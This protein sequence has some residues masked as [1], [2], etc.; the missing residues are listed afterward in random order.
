MIN[1]RSIPRILTAAIVAQLLTMGATAQ[2][3]EAPIMPTTLSETYDTWTVQCGNTGT[4]DQTKRQCQMSQEL[5]QQD[6][7]QR[8]LLFAV[9]EG[10]GNAK[11]TLILPFGLLLSPGVHIEIA[12]KEL[13]SG[14]FQTCLPQGCL[15]EIELS[16]MALDQ[17]Q[18][19]EKLSVLMTVQNGQ[20][21]KTDVS[22]KGFGAAYRRLLALAAG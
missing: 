20:P 4:G 13:A 3:T 10:E 2:E 8:M 9:T 7:R 5:L 17:L 12:E 15:V 19:G 11:A 6:S 18:T 1:S 14:G 22:L 21:M 16:S